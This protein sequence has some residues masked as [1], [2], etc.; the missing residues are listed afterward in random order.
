MKGGFLALRGTKLSFVLITLVCTTL[1]MWGWDK[2]PFL[3]SLLPQSQLIKLSPDIVIGSPLTNTTSEMQ[4]HADNNFGTFVR[5]E[6]FDKQEKHAFDLETQSDSVKGYKE[7]TN[8]ACNYAKGKWVTDDRRTFY[9]GGR[10]RQWLSEMWACRLTDR[11]D[12]AYE[13]FRWQPTDCEMD[14]FSGSKFLRRMRNKTL[15]FIGDSL[16]RQ[17]FQSLMC[18]ITGGKERSDVIDVGWEY[19]LV[20]SRGAV[21][22]DGWAYRF[23]RTNTTIL[24]YWSACL[25]D[26][27]K[28]NPSDPKSQ[29]AMHLDRPPEFLTQYMDRFNVLV[30]NTG[31]HWNRG[32]FEGN[33][34]V[35]H[36]GGLPNPDKNI[37]EAKN[38]TIHSIVKWVDSQLPNHPNLR[39]FYRS[40]SPRHF[41]NGD[42]N[43]GGTC[44]NTNPLSKGNEVLKEESRDPLVDMAVVGTKVSFL[45]I[46]ALSELRDEG[47]LSR[48]TI[49]PGPRT[50]DCLHWCLPG[51]PDTWNE[52]LFAQ[53]FSFRG[54]N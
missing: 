1:L 7:R 13:R 2:A 21:R 53:L 32:K 37:L 24:F 23:P 26:L 22:P 4:R 31:H 29:I 20:K 18:M 16:G 19:G 41:F 28:L 9:S 52:I 14:E 38:L 50:Q 10:C 49:K 5:N 12:F 33:H 17:Q 40:I 39:A 30:L 8:Q 36:V 27:Q 42:W 47:H 35:M 34:W 45:D 11:T 25:C 3:V 48:Y 44:D 6:T 46:T 54:K 51:I 43:T 15:A